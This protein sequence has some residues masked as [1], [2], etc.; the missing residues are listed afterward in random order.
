[1]IK[2]TEQ[3]S[4]AVM[5]VWNSYL[6]GGEKYTYPITGFTHQVLDQHRLEVIPEVKR[7]VDKFTNGSVP[8]EEFRSHIE[9]INKKNLLWGF[10]GA[11]GQVFF[12]TFV[13]A[14][15]EAKLHNEL[16]NL[17]KETLPAPVNSDFAVNNIRTFI[18]FIRSITAVVPEYRGGLKVVSIPFFLSYFWQI[19]KPETWPIYYTSMVDELKALEIWEPSDNV[20][21]NYSDFYELNYQIIDLIEN[22]TGKEVKL[23]DI[24]HA[25]WTSAFLK[26]VQPVVQQVTQP[27]TQPVIQPAPGEKPAFVEV[28][29]AKPIPAQEVISPLPVRESKT[30]TV[31]IDRKAIQKMIHPSLSDSFIPPIVSTLSALAAEDPQVA[32]LCAQSGE[33]VEKVFE[34][35]LAVLFRMLGFDTNSLGQGHGRVPNGIAT[36]EEHHY[37][38]VYDA[39]VSRQGFSVE[40]DEPELRDFILKIGDRLRKQGYRTIYFMVIS[41]GFVGEYDKASR[42]L[43]IETGVNEVILVEVSSLLLLL[44]NKLRNPE[45]TLGP[46]HIQKLLAASGLLTADTVSE[47]FE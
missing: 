39:K 29:E 43:K 36:C 40:A 21:R 16:N 32:A 18:N 37:A 47:F 14:S 22:K 24:E 33:T 5:K 19:Q 31:R 41:S 9:E 12:N 2:L 3:Q 44:E 25:I 8:V 20:A 10:S 27:V 38:I 4:E 45:I 26:T 46:K 13:K 1:M 6:D 15:L 30:P 17:F 7:M 11:N 42:T 35:R 23:W 34:E 28:P